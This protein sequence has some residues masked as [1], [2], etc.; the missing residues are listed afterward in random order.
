MMTAPHNELPPKLQR[1][2]RLLTVLGVLLI[3]I[4]VIVLVALHRLP[5]PVRVLTGLGD[6]FIGCVLLVLVRQKR[7][8]TLR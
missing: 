5:P 7:N 6:I 3:V 2:L 8:G 4:G 1:Q